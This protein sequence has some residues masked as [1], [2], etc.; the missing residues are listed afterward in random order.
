[1]ITLIDG[2]IYNV[3]SNSPMKLTIQYEYQRSGADM[4]YRFY[5]HLW[6]S[7]SSSWY[8]NTLRLK[9][10]LNGSE[11]FSVDNRSYDKGWSFSDTTGWFTVS[12]KTSGTV[13]F[14][15]SV[16]D[17]LNSSWCQYT[18]STYSLT[19]A[20]AY[21]SI[22]KF[23][24]SKK[25]GFAGLTE[26]SASWG[27]AHTCSLIQYSKDNGSS[28]TTVSSDANASSGSFSITGLTPGTGYNFKLRVKR[29]DSGLTTDSSTNY[30]STYNINTITSGTP[31]VSNGSSLSV[32]AS[33]P[34]GATC[35]I[36]LE[37]AGVS[38]YSKSGTSATFS[39]DE[40]A[41]LMQYFTFSKTFTI[42]VVACTLDNNGTEKYWHYVDGTYTIIN[43]NPNFTDFNYMDSDTDIINITGNSIYIVK[44]KSTLK[45]SIPSSKKMVAQNYAT[46]VSYRIEVGN[47]TGSIA[48]SENDVALELG[49]LNIS[50]AVNMNVSAIDSRGNIT[51]KTKVLYVIDYES[52]TQS[53]S[54]RR[55]NEFENTTRIN[56][57]GI[58]SLVT[59]GT[60]NKNTIQ[61]ARFRYKESTL[62]TWNAWQS[63][64]INK[65]DNTYKCNQQV[66]DLD[67]EKSFNFEIEVKDKFETVTLPYF[68]AQG[69]PIEFISATKKN[70]GIGCINEHEE[71]SLAT[72]GNIYLENGNV[73]LKSGNEVLDYEVISEWD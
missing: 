53:V 45:V 67:N 56:A 25:S 38:R 59:C 70:I 55:I 12:N 41:S 7:N 62:S 73:Y 20:P 15:V 14:Y 47:L 10:Y 13:P 40:I 6:L 9:M 54:I 44:N 11:V 58:F 8:S 68:V 36:R 34:S 24:L 71:Y 28:W 52:P 1:M 42:R 31:N 61:S 64:T 57:S 49:R 3:S 48:Y 51:T 26:I 60:E 65:T 2:T 17:I 50:G 5:Y 39:V 46:P 19:V 18:S 16:S 35:R 22:T 37:C 63:L 4:K 29:R 33:N 72:R 69:I 23:D 21:T 30:Q 32:T 27:A 43:S 66:V